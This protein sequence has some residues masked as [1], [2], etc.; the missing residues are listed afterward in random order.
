VI[1]SQPCHSCTHHQF[2]L[3]DLIPDA[4]RIPPTIKSACDNPVKISGELP[5]DSQFSGYLSTDDSSKYGGG[6]R[7]FTH[8]IRQIFIE[9]IIMYQESNVINTSSLVPGFINPFNDIRFW[10]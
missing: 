8:L 2:V 4:F 5:R 7:V 9:G 10:G 6:S 3:L 1:P